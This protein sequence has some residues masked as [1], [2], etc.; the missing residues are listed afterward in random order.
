MFSHGPSAPRAGANLG[1]QRVR[2][3]LLQGRH[4]PWRSQPW[5]VRDLIADRGFDSRRETGVSSLG[6]SDV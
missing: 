4:V 2:C 3:P 5:L 1:P 6:K